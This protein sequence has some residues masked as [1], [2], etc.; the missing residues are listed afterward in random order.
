MSSEVSVIG[1]IFAPVTAIAGA[2]VAVAKAIVGLGKATGDCAKIMAKDRRLEEAIRDK[3]KESCIKE[4][5]PDKRAEYIEKVI[6]SFS[7]STLIS[8]KRARELIMSVSEDKRVETAFKLLELEAK[9][10]M[11]LE[12]LGTL[13]ELSERLGIESDDIIGMLEAFT[14]VK[15]ESS[16]KH[17]E[18]KL[19]ELSEAI[20]KRIDENKALIE[21]KIRERVI[22]AEAVEVKRTEENLFE[23]VFG[24]DIAAVLDNPPKEGELRELIDEKNISEY[25]I[26]AYAAITILKGME[27]FE[28]YSEEI[29]PLYVSIEELSEREDLSLEDYKYLV[30]IKLESLDAILSRLESEEQYKRKMRFTEL[31]A[32]TNAYRKELGMKEVTLAYEDTDEQL[33]ALE[34]STKEI[35]EKYIRTTRAKRLLL[36]LKLR[37]TEKRYRHITGADKVIEKDGDV[38]H[39]SYYITPDGK[40]ILC[41]SVN[42]K[43]ILDEKVVGVKIAGLADDAS[44]VLSAQET[45]CKHS[46]EILDELF[47]DDDVKTIIDDPALE[48]AESV[49]FTGILPADIIEEIKAKKEGKDKR[50]LVTGKER[51]IK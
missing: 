16:E 25:R 43:G 13:T 10:K 38:R 11:A 7:E 3:Y 35:E 15:D 30:G 34:E 4:E 47:S 18:E 5:S 21:E 32:L 48:Y 17:L 31:L 9:Y 33:K 40:N 12:N 42:E 27:G 24:G 39:L 20:L 41:I 49:D 46:K 44:S 1:A 8:K 26:R 29:V 19:K 28:K 14:S 36:D 50:R 37:Y 45:F 23:A 2:G 6:E 51:T 22:E